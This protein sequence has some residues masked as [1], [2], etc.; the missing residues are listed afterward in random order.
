[1]LHKLLNTDLAKRYARF[2]LA[3]FVL[4]VINVSVQL[5]AH[6]SM[7]MQMQQQQT[8]MQDMSSCHCPPA[9]CDSVLALDN[10]SVDG[11]A[12]VPSL[13]YRSTTL[14]EVLDQNSG[15]LNQTQHI[16]KIFLN[17]TQA[18]PPTLLIKTLLLI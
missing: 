9:F 7:K 1:M 10:Q 4:S 3:L 14:L 17:V 12:T 13:I 8:E 15:Q 11:V 6:A 18:E 5:P 16:E 2:I